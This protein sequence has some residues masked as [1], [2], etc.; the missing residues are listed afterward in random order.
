ALRCVEEAPVAR[1][2]IGGAEAVKGPGLPAGPRGIAAPTLM[3]GLAQ[4]LARVEVEDA[5][6]GRAAVAAHQEAARGQAVRLGDAPQR[7]IR[8][9]LRGVEDDADVHHDVDESALRRHERAQVAAL[10]VEPPREGL[11]RL[12][13]DLVDCRVAAEVVPALP[14]GPEEEAQVVHGTI[15]L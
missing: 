3:R 6:V 10:L 15:R 8:V 7:G 1:E 4:E 12:D 2:T 13:D 5:L 11:P 9:L 14:R